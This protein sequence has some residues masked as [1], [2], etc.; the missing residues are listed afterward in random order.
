MDNDLVTALRSRGV[1]V[2]TAIEAG[3]GAR[4]DQEQLAFA[5]QNGYVLY[6]FNV[7]D[8]YR[9]HGEWVSI[10]KQHHGMILVTQQ[11]FSVGEQLR[12]L[13]RLRSQISERGMRNRVEFLSNWG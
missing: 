1:I 10:G 13:L 4:P 6:T 2:T 11:R 5:A 12:R 9:L 3:R 8:F 7:A